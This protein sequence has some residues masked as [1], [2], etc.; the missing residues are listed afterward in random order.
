MKNST[1]KE[2]SVT[3][4]TCQCIHFWMVQLHPKVW[5]HPSPPSAWVGWEALCRCVSS[6]NLGFLGIA[7]QSSN[8]VDGSGFMITTS[9]QRHCKWWLVKITLFQWFFQSLSCVQIVLLCS[10]AS[11][12]GCIHLESWDV[13]EMER[14]SVCG[15]GFNMS[16]ESQLALVGSMAITREDAICLDQHKHT[17]RCA[18]AIWQ[19]INMNKQVYARNQPL[20]HI[21]S[22]NPSPDSVMQRATLQVLDFVNLGSP[23][24]LRSPARLENCGNACVC[25]YVSIRYFVGRA[26]IQSDVKCYTHSTI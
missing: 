12:S 18:D 25:F 17:K 24:S 1:A 16:L 13:H 26:C 11:V 14:E 5:V 10:S 21:S 9:W 19:W 7:I 23:L 20:H 3:I 15:L 8:V 6:V 2:H 4:L 22:T